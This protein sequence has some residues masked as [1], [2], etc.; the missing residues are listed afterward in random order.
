MSPLAENI[1]V[2]VLL[3]GGLFVALTA[4]AYAVVI[5][6]VIIHGFIQGFR[7]KL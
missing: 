7:G 5:P 1:T 3:F 6:L 2:A 4:A